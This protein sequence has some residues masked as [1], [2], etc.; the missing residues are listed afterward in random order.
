MGSPFRFLPPFLTLILT[1]A[2][3]LIASEPAPAPAPRSAWDGVFSQEQVARGKK[4]YE[5]LCA[6]CHGDTLGGGEDSPA[7]VDKEF[8]KNWTG[9]TLGKMVEYTREEMPSDGPGKVT[10]KQSTDL[11]AFLLSMNGFPAGQTELPPDL[12][13]LNQIAITPKK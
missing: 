13:V 10:R 2:T 9:K 1:G 11:T 8:L 12:E 4:N 3:I 5:T 6:R 7:L